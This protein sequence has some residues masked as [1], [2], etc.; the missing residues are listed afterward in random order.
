MKAVFAFLCLFSFSA[1]QA[2]DIYQ[3]DIAAMLSAKFTFDG[4]KTALNWDLQ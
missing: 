1:L 2:Q 3:D 4:A